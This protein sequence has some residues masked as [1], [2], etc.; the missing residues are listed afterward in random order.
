MTYVRYNDVKELHLEWTSL[1]NAR[2]PQCA[3]TDNKDLP[4]SSLTIEQVKKYF[5]VEFVNNLESMYSCGNYGDPIVNPD[6]VEIVRYFV[7]N[8]CDRIALHT[9]G[10]TRDKEFWTDL[11]KMGIRVVFAIDGLE[12][13]NHIYRVGVQW[14]RLMENVT[15]FISAG[16]NAT[17]AFLLFAHN[18]HQVEEARQLSID[19][20]F[21]RFID[22]A[23]SRFVGK[24][25]KVINKKTKQEI[26]E[27]KESQ[28]HHQAKE[29]AIKTYGSWEDYLAQTPITCKTLNAK[30]VYVDFQGIVYPCCWM[31]HTYGKYHN[32]KELLN[33]RYGTHAVVSLEHYSLEEI[34][35]NTAWFNKD[36]TETWKPGNNRLNVCSTTCG[37]IYKP[38]TYKKD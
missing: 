32:I 9:N 35:N 29:T 33:K 5:P 21:R 19:M 3:R 16:G 30:S 37:G 7:E 15:T 31:G 25:S 18:E 17:W 14:D 28:K 24:T 36:L 22:K 6:C 1:C 38:R 2:C 20:G 12:D 26:K 11:G 23:S 8:G 34:L 13:T 4:L 27:A 10:G